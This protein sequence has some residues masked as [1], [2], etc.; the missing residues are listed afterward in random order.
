MIK[1]LWRGR[2]LYTQSYPLA[3]VR[4]T[5][6]SQMVVDLRKLG[7][8][9]AIDE[10]AIH[11]TGNQ[12]VAT[13]GGGAA[14]GAYN[15]EG[16]ITLMNWTTAPQASGLIPINGVTS[17][18]LVVDRAVIQGSFQ[19]QTALTD[20]TGTNAVDFWVRFALKRDGFNAVKKSIE[21]SH[22]PK[23]YSTDL[24]SINFGTRDQLFTGGTGT[25]DL[26]GLNIEIWANL[27]VDANPDHIHATELF[28]LVLPI[29][30]ANSA[31]LVNQLPAGVFYDNLYLV[32][33]SAGVLVDTVLNNVD[34]D[35][36]GRYWLPKGEGNAKFIREVFTKE[37]FA[38]PNSTLTGIYAIPLR[39]GLWSR[40][41]DAVSGPIQLVLDV[42]NPGT[43]Q[44]RII[45][46]KIIPGAVKKTSRSKAGVVSVQGLPDVA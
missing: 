38:N 6:Q 16:L 27:D 7:I 15:P 45:G 42:N 8:S 4:T 26:T 20:G 46:R 39:D 36:G 44:V 3:G 18:A 5:G 17:R 24:I 23:K 12:I 14:T 40:A 9:D 30:A 31:F 33:E 19:T 2:R 41:L 13:G 35:G 29:A 1:E 34:I 32:T 25:W 37:A 43:T 10:I 21:Y 22:F 28:E 11:V